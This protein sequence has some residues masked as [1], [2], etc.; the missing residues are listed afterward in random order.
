MNSTLN[1]SKV[2]MPPAFMATTRQKILLRSQGITD[3]SFCEKQSA[4][5]HALNVIGNM[6]KGILSLAKNS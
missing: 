4:A 2:P 5:M 6:T 3:T 1:S